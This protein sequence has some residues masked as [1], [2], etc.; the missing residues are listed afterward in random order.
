MVSSGSISSASGAV[1]YYTKAEKDR[2]SYYAVEAKG[3]WYGA[4]AEE[5]GLVG[6]VDKEE[7]RNLLEGKS[8]DGSEQLVERPPLKDKDGN[9]LY[10]K[11]GNPLTRCAY[12]FTFTPDKSFSLAMVEGG[13]EQL[14]A[15][16]N[17]AV[18]DGIDFAVKEG[19]ITHK[20]TVDGER[21]LQSSF[22]PVFAL[23]NHSLSRENDA[24]AHVHCVLINTC[25]TESGETKALDFK[26]M[27][28]HKY[29]LDQVISAS[30]ASRAKELGYGIEQGEHAPR[31]AGSDEKVEEIKSKRSDQIKDKLAENQANGV[32]TNASEREQKLA[33][34]LDT[35]A[36]KSHMDAGIL[37]DRRM[38]EYEQ[39][40]TTIDKY[41]ADIKEAGEKQRSHEAHHG[42]LSARECVAQAAENL[43]ANEAAF[44]K[45]DLLVDAL[46][47]GAGNQRETSIVPAMQE[48]IKDGSLHELEGG[49]KGMMTTPEMFDKERGIIR[50]VRETAGTMK[51]A[52]VPQD[53]MEAINR[54]EASKQAEHGA[55]YQLKDGQKEAAMH[56]LTS[57]D[58]YLGVQG[59]AGTG[60]TAMLEGVRETLEPKGYAILGL[61]P[62]GAA[63]KELQAGSGI[64]SKTLHDFLNQ[65]ER[66]GGAAFFS[67]EEFALAKGVKENPDKILL[68][69]DEASMV[70][71]KLA[72]QLQK[73]AGESGA[74]V[75]FLGDTAQLQA[76]GAGKVFSS[77]QKEESFKTATMDE[78]MRQ[79]DGSVAQ[80]VVGAIA[81]KDAGLAFEIM[82]KNGMIHEVKDKGE[83]V[84]AAA[85][86]F[87]G[88]GI[89]STLLIA[90]RNSD[91]EALNEAAREMRIEAGQIERGHSFTVR[92]PAGLTQA[93]KH[94][95]H[96]YNV[97]D[98]VVFQQEINGIKAG[99]EGKIIDVDRNTGQIKADMYDKKADAIDRVEIDLKKDG[100]KLAL[101]EEKR[102]ELAAG[103]KLSCLKNDKG[104]GIA[105]S[106]LPTLKN[107]DAKGNMTMTFGAKVQKDKEGK[108]VLDDK[109]N[110]VMKGG[111]EVKANIKQ[112]PYV[113]H[114]YAISTHKAQGMSIPK[115][116]LFHDKGLNMEA[117]Y[118]K[119]SR[120]QEGLSAY[121]GD[122]EAMKRE[123]A[124]AQVKES[125]LGY[126]KKLQSLDAQETKVL[127]KEAAAAK[128]PAAVDKGQAAAKEAAAKGPAPV[129]KGQAIPEK[130]KAASPAMPSYMQAFKGQ[131]K[132]MMASAKAFYYK[133]AAPEKYKELQAYA[134]DATH[135]AGQA[136]GKEADRHLTIGN[137]EKMP[138]L[139][140]G[141]VKELNDRG[142]TNLTMKTASGQVETMDI[143]KEHAMNIARGRADDGQIKNGIETTREA[144]KIGA[145]LK[146]GVIGKPEPTN[147]TDAA[148]AVLK[149]SST[150]GASATANGKA[151]ESKAAETTKSSETAK[152]SDTS[153]SNDN[154]KTTSTV[155]SSDA[156][157]TADTAKAKSSS[158]SNTTSSSKSSTQSKSGST[159]SSSSSASK[160]QSKSVERS[161]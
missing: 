24:N 12:D 37:N 151:V 98:L 141:A 55:S 66:K 121:T 52:M 152:A 156:S 109:G 104:L 28:S 130:T 25:V 85:K 31:I 72:A 149:E 131:V 13:D 4:G 102:I 124:A 43:T 10:D 155:K 27:V 88:S 59:Y 120:T 123:G 79:K 7:F 51:P 111:K 36:H 117:N 159:G 69:V 67:Q 77:L 153:K 144:G 161:R 14:R 50:E 96:N 32:M 136:K 68:V 116:V 95:A 113:A 133:H 148:K 142:Y 80:E 128:G 134:K 150:P 132:E 99:R 5:L 89:N 157:K 105:N 6:E 26:E 54:F 90:D 140:A 21:G 19:W 70:D 74:Q 75:V 61:A 78:I 33:A 110:E 147:H 38:S 92:A 20:E 84:T 60:K 47:L 49:K 2:D 97:G 129:D 125:T 53:A 11:E 154:T 91:R 30:L 145:D 44:T 40:G 18:K 100:A 1:D 3:Q 143:Q 139:K 29:V 114:G 42:V 34:C 108:A 8:K 41:Q 83:R 122:K 45:Y 62:T 64:E 107:I 94:Q 137:L 93:E 16:M 87:V 126:T 57:S 101:Y 35:R 146:A 118:V 158:T 39:A 119:L 56:I 22:K 103:D 9:I 15:A 23:Y 160:S 65:Y 86:D 106:E 63:A 82:D 115:A 48:M 73:V 127:E 46:K 135:Q 81:N 58:Q 76:V 138:H 112:Y 71:I 17:D